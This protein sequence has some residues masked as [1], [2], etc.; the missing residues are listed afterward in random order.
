VVIFEIIV[1]I[2]GLA[3]ST[4]NHDDKGFSKLLD[5]LLPF[6][7]VKD[8]GGVLGFVLQFNN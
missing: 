6:A 1:F 2:V 3:V 8:V 4:Q 7:A 5:I